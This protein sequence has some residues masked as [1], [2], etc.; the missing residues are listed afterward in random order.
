M[1][2]Q[3]FLT[4]CL[5]IVS[6]AA[7]AVTINKALL[8]HNGEVTLFDGNDLQ[9]AVNAAV[10]GDTI[11][12]TLG[13]FKPFT[14]NKKITVRGTGTR[15][16]IDGSVNISISGTPNLTSNLLEALK[17]SGDVTLNNSV[18]NLMLHK[19]LITGTVKLNGGVTEGTIKECQIGNISF[20]ASIDNLYVER[21]YIT[22]TF[23]LSSTIKSMTVVNTK[24]YTVQAN[25]GATNNTTFVNC[26]IYALYT[27]NFAGTIINSIIQSPANQ[28]DFR[29]SSFILNSTVLLN[30]VINKYI[31]NVNTYSSGSFIIGSSSVT[32]NCY[33]VST[34]NYVTASCASNPDSSYKGTDGTIVGIYGGDTP[35]TGILP[36]S[37]PKVTSSDLDLDNVNKVLNVKLTVSPQ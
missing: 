3:L 7:S 27:A 4:V 2:K 11:Y 12:L 6:M 8:Q 25:S 32:Q 34:Q 20:G 24:L 28:I 22:S 35:Y 17:V 29:N 36:P 31:Y 14:I 26:N 13:T 33:L 1:T 18:S 37:V 19:C 21:C 9:A 5:L 23:T 16:I 15:S 10:D 30:S